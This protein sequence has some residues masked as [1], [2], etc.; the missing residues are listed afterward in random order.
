MG[1]LLGTRV[2]TQLASW[3]LAIGSDQIAVWQLKWMACCLSGAGH[4]ADRFDHSTLCE[5]GP[6]AGMVDD[7]TTVEENLVAGKKVRRCGKWSY[8]ARVR[9]SMVPTCRYLLG[10]LK[11][12]ESI[13]TL[14]RTVYYSTVGSKVCLQARH[15]SCE[16]LLLLPVVLLA[17]A[18]PAHTSQSQW[19]HH[20]WQVVPDA[21]LLSWPQQ[22]S[23]TP[24]PS[25]RV[26]LVPG[27]EPLRCTVKGAGSLQPAACSR[28]PIAVVSDR[29]CD[30]DCDCG[31]EHNL[32][33]PRPAA[34][35]P[36]L[37]ILHL[38][39]SRGTSP[40]PRTVQSVCQP[41]A[42]ANDVY[43]TAWPP[44]FASS[45]GI[46]VP[47]TTPPGMRDAILIRRMGCGG[48]TS[49][50]CSTSFSGTRTETGSLD[51]DGTATT[52][53][54]DNLDNSLSRVVQRIRR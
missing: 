23:T 25:H 18:H 43:E 13:S 53:R 44:I 40:R 31:K 21:P 30:S 7:H 34:A 37:A 14:P 27:A 4:D 39:S 22:Q 28:P 41:L 11:I 54:K 10:R 20:T 1:G 26:R 35:R 3:Q 6:G 19:H 2:G 16:P 47:S 46:R 8:R 12:D 15:P 33:T 42:F 49:P 36:L 32:G 29:D 24:L 45:Q 51:E 9:T 52:H 5:G 50:L 38:Q 48:C 17:S